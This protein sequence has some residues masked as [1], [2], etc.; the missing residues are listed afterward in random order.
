MK[1][2]EAVLWTSGH[3]QA[4]NVPLWELSCVCLTTL[5]LE[6][7]HQFITSAP[8]SWRLSRITGIWT[9]V[10]I[11]TFVM[12]HWNRFIRPNP[13]SCNWPVL[14]TVTGLLSLSRS[15]MIIISKNWYG[16]SDQ[17]TSGANQSSSWIP[18][19]AL[20]ES[21]SATAQRLWTCF[22]L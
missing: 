1:M 21:W 6:N 16:A 10:S 14:T 11:Q 8:S 4:S 18:L 12:K 13:P 2:V 20:D 19:H 17:Y 5:Q 7:F 3:A 15:R 22:L 9:A